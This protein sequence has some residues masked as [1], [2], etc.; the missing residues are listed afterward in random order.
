L[1]IVSVGLSEAARKA[2]QSKHLFS[3]A[4]SLEAKEGPSTTL[5]SVQ[6]DGTL[7]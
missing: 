5:R 4:Q 6:D 1:S 2:A 7:E 3:D